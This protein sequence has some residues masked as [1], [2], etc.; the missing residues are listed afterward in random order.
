MCGIIGYTGK[1]EVTPILVKGLKKLEY[2]G[3]DSAGIAIA[4]G[5]DMK[6]F[7]EQGKVVMLE[8]SIANSGEDLSSY[9]T[10]I[11]HTRWATH[12]APMQKNA[13]PHYSPIHG[14]ALVHNGII[15]NYQG[16][17]A[18]LEAAGYVFN[19][20]TDTE[21]L[22]HLVDFYYEGDLQKAATKA[23]HEV[24][25]T[26]GICVICENEPGTIITARKGSPIVIGLSEDE[27]IIASDAAAI[28][29]YTRQVIYLDDGDVAK[30][31]NNKVDIFTMQA[32]PVN[33]KT[34]EINWSED[35]TEKGGYEHYMLKEIFEQP[36]A[37]GNA[38]R[39]RLDKERGN[40]VLSGINISTREL[41]E[42][43]RVLI[44]GCGTSLNAGEVGE[45]AIEDFAGILSEVEQAA[46][47][48]YRNPII[49]SHD[50]VLAISQ[51]GETADTLAAVR[52][53]ADKGAL[54]AGLVNVVGSTIARET[55]RGLYLH[56]GPEI[57]VAST[58]A[59]TCQVAALLMVA[60]KFARLRRMSRDEGINFCKEIERIPS[61][62]Q[63]VL[64]KNDE[65]AKVAA[66]FT[67]Y[68][69]MFFIGRGYM[70]PVAKEGALKLK[71]ISYI[72][73]EA[74]HSSELKHG[75]IALLTENMPVV[76][77]LNDGPGKDKNFGNVSECRARSAPILGII[78]E[79]DEEAK[80]HCDH[81]IEVPAS[82]LQTATITS[83]VALQLFSYHV[84]RLKGCSIDQPRNLAK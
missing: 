36:T 55:E 74:Y 34:S 64:D 62:V 2:R 27:T 80:S 45:Y 59:F 38:I 65:I 50:L 77:L 29:N 52:E 60:L 58:K 56:A 8:E 81:Y 63:Q 70:Y 35:A 17:K 71:E 20:D 57:S 42:I 61:L 24:V 14:I 5:E 21:V 54:V 40:S 23:L 69:S 13:H 6:I 4:N 39:G 68:T 25:G 53:A 47:F 67:E 15:E 1:R 18:N 84:A 7:K 11:A 72:H 73:A 33:R 26:Y 44:V 19:S 31:K 51:S 41:V 37:I 22:A 28:I 49:N 10:G 12:G 30:I 83:T 46:E 76:A 79:G 3:Y 32:S 78:T 75:P 9:N 16:L 43:R 82:P 48:R 66:H